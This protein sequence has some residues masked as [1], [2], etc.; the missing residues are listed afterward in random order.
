MWSEELKEFQPQNHVIINGVNTMQASFPYIYKQDPATGKPYEFSWAQP[1]FW[2]I[3]SGTHLH[4]Q[5][6]SLD[7]RKLV[8]IVEDI[9]EE[10]HKNNQELK[11]SYLFFTDEFFDFKQSKDF[12]LKDNNLALFNR[13]IGIFGLFTEGEYNWILNFH[14]SSNEIVT[15][16]AHTPQQTFAGLIDFLKNNCISTQ[17]NEIK[18][19]LSK[20]KIDEDKDEDFE[21]LGSFLPTYRFKF[22]NSTTN[23]NLVHILETVYINKEWYFYAEIRENVQNFEENF[24]SQ[25]LQIC[26]RSIFLKEN[27]ISK[28][29]PKKSEH[30]LFDFI[31]ALQNSQ[32]DSIFNPFFKIK[33]QIRPDNVEK[34]DFEIGLKENKFIDAY[35]PPKQ[36][37]ETLEKLNRGPCMKFV[38][39]VDDSVNILSK[40]DANQKS[41]FFP[42]QETDLQDKHTG[43][44]QLGGRYIEEKNGELDEWPKGEKLPIEVEESV[45]KSDPEWFQEQSEPKEPEPQKE[46]LKDVDMKVAFF[47]LSLNSFWE[48]DSCFLLAKEAKEKNIYIEI[49]EF[50]KKTENNVFFFS[51]I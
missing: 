48:G 11:Q 32:S 2:E 15:I 43:I 16:K 6:N 18:D 34:N 51:I 33:V 38:V 21:S 13:K 37:F 41:F 22:F 46:P 5:T 50:F 47:L 45:R 25:K 4:D 3:H 9:Q 35:L 7:L 36:I 28:H 42:W 27:N 12:H 30:S 49:T 1:S 39:V 26:E 40:N 19:K 14:R 44:T 31:N 24:V 17:E 20:F 23:S 10:F 8:Q 29:S